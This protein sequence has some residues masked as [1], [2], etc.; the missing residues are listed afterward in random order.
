MS[1]GTQWLVWKFESDSTLSDALDGLLGPFPDAL[2]EL[3]LGEVKENKPLDKRE[4]EVGLGGG[5]GRRRGRKRE[6]AGG[7]DQEGWEGG[8][9][10]GVS[11]SF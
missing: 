1:K 7:R 8:W 5:G 2:E 10:G 9:G 6:G 4:S 3:L 11:A